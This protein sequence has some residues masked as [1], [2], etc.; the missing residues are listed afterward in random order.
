[1]ITLIQ[2]VLNANAL[3]RGDLD[4]SFDD[5][6]LVAIVWQVVQ[7][8]KNMA[9]KKNIQLDF[10]IDTN[11]AAV[12]TDKS[13]C[14]QIIDNL[15]SNAIKFSN[16]G[17]NVNIKINSD[18][19]KVFC[20]IEDHGPGISEEDQEKLF[21]KYAVLSAKPTG[22]EHSSRLGLSIVKRL[23]EGI[24]ADINYE[25]TLGIGTMFT[26]SFNKSSSS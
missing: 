25:S 10:K 21:K 6:D 11:V 8:L 2:N 17:S 7:N 9:D 12:Y 16:S 1:M 20:S 15:L 19:E 18:E 23:V 26:V 13:A 3:E 14:T 22:G 24:G 5:Y 4:F